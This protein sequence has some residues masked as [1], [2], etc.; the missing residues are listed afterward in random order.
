MSITAKQLRACKVG[1]SLCDMHYGLQLDESLEE[2]QEHGRVRVSV[3]VAMQLIDRAKQIA[4]GSYLNK[5]LCVVDICP[6]GGITCAYSY[7]GRY[8]GIISF[9]FHQ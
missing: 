1:D 7:D 4:G 5:M 2:Y 3:D 9:G 6:N 8:A